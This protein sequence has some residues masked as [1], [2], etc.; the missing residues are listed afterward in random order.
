MIQREVIHSPVAL[1]LGA[2]A[3]LLLSAMMPAA[4]DVLQD[5]YDK[6]HPVWVDGRATDTE[7]SGDAVELSIAGDK[8]RNCRFLRINA[9]SMD[10]Q[11][12]LADAQITRIDAP[13]VGATRETGVQALG[14]YRIAKVP[15]AAKYVRVTVEHECGGRVVLSRLVTVAL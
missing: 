10:V 8:R 9:Y 11:G 2:V 4:L 12:V 6:A 14:R 1:A 7:R 5:Q 13:M 3:G 15:A